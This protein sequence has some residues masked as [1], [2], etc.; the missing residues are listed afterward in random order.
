MPK[1]RRTVSALLACALALFLAVLPGA[2]PAAAR[3]SS[4]TDAESPFYLSGS[5]LVYVTAT[6]KCYHDIPDCGSTKTAYLLSLAEACR[7]GYKPCGRCDPPMPVATD[8]APAFPDG[9]V[10]VYITVGNDCYHKKASCGSMK[11]AV[12]VTMEEA[13]YLGKTPCK[14]CRPPQ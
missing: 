9:S 8:V 6:G 13:L 5:T 10:I 12:P 4:G 11:N 3:V 7:I 14:K 1:T 2:A